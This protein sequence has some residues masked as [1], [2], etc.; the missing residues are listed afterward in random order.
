[1]YNRQRLVDSTSGVEIGAFGTV[2]GC[3]CVFFFQPEDGI[4]ALVRSRGLEDVYKRQ[5]PAFARWCGGGPI[6]IGYN[7]SLIHI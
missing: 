2:N 7:L 3:V 6:V 1:M 4:R 5:V